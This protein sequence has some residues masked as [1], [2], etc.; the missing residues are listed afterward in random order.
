V[1]LFWLKAVPWSAIISNA[2]VILDAAK[3]RAG[4]MRLAWL[5]LAGL[6]LL[7]GWVLTR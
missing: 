7:A 5:A 2:P 3:G 6:A 4:F 1:S